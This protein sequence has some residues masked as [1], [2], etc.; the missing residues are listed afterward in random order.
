RL[1]L[2]ALFVAGCVHFPSNPPHVS[3]SPA[4]RRLRIRDVRVFAA[5]HTTA[6]DHRDVVVDGDTIT[7]VGDTG[8]VDAG[9]AMVIDGRGRTLLPGLVDMH[10]HSTLTAAPPWYPAVP[11]PRHA[12]E[13]HLFAGVT[14]I[15]DMG[16][17][18]DALVDARWR[19]ARGE[20][21]GPRVVFAGRIITRRGG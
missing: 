18:L 3:R 10:A 9:D 17:D 2:T 5:T 7:V 6:I 8:V 20:W 13:A 12:L 19:V 1:A 11:D 21:L 4:P 16:S 14:T 15:C